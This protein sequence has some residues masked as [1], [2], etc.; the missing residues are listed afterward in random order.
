MK[1][2]LVLREIENPIS[3]DN[4]DIGSV[5]NSPTSDHETE[6]T[7]HI[8]KYIGNLPI[9]TNMIICNEC[10]AKLV[11]RIGKLTSSSPT[12]ARFKG[13]GYVAITFNG[14]NIKY[15]DIAK[16]R[17]LVTPKYRHFWVSTSGDPSE[18]TFVV[19]VSLS[20]S[21]ECTNFNDYMN[22]CIELMEFS[23]EVKSAI[24][25][26]RKIQKKEAKIIKKKK[27]EDNKAK[28]KESVKKKN[29]KS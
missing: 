12:V 8:D 21:D 17:N 20:N 22:T 16:L 15:G 1:D 7:Y 9:D 3:T 23:E 24:R 4:V 10:I 29:K 25:E 14:T 11:S 27:K 19:R 2:V 13:H 28:K 26:N 18:F 6:I 5:P